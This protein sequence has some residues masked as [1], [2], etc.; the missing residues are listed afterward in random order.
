MVYFVMKAQNVTK[1]KHG[2]VCG[3]ACSCVDNTSNPLLWG[4]I[5]AIS[6]LFLVFV[7]PMFSIS[8]FMCPNLQCSQ[9]MHPVANPLKI[10]LRNTEMVLVGLFLECH[11]LNMGTN[12]PPVL[13]AHCDESPK[14]H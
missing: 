2:C 8:V 9:F 12:Q 5:G 10:A 3:I 1:S 13:L 14:C 7:C 6:V 11:L 4:P